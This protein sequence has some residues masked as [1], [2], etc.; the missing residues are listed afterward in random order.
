MP[1][2]SNKTEPMDTMYN[3]MIL[4]PTDFSILRVL[5]DGR[6]VAANI[7]MELES[8]QP[9]VS[10]RLGSLYDYGLVNKVGPNENSGLYEITD[11]GERAIEH[12]SLYKEDQEQ[13]EAIVEGDIGLNESDSDSGQ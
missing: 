1:I 7:H 8:A 3:Q 11:M 12:E 9:Y 2:Q 6:N 10:E 4:R 5:T 13:F